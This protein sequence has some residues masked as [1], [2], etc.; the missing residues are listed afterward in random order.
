MIETAGHTSLYSR[1]Q[2][3]R[4]LCLL[5]FTSESLLS[6]AYQYTALFILSYICNLIWHNFCFI[7]YTVYRIFSILAK[8]KDEQPIK[9]NYSR[10]V[11]LAHLVNDIRLF[12]K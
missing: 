10:F 1:T 4:Y 3:W 6:D 8:E 9:D 5:C 11:I 7:M 12:M 2:F